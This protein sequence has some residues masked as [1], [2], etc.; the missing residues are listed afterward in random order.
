MIDRS[1]LQ[2][3]GLTPGTREAKCEQAGNDSDQL[4]SLFA[5][6]CQGPGQCLNQL[7]GGTGIKERKE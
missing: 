3:D 2:C 1:L 5:Y 4:F 6:M 7:L